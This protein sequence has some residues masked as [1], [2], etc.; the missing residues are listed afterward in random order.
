MATLAVVARGVGARRAACAWASTCKHSLET[1][2]SDPTLWHFGSW[3]DAMKAP[4]WEWWSSALGDKGFEINLCAYE[5]PY[6]VN[7]LEFL[8]SAAGATKVFFEEMGLT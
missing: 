5:W 2:M 7:P 1:I 3:V 6:T 4:G 8:V